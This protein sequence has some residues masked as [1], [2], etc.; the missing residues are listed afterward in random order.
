[1]GSDSAENVTVCYHVVVPVEQLSCEGFVV[2]VVG[3]YNLAEVDKFVVV[4]EAAEVAPQTAKRAIVV[5][6]VSTDIDRRFTVAAAFVVGDSI[7]EVLDRIVQILESSFDSWSDLLKPT[8][9]KQ[10][11]NMPTSTLAESSNM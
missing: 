3:V 4:V 5:L 2:G 7:L 11:I 6:A 8:F 10:A 9:A 1:M